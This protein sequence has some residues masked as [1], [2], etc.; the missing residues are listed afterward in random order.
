MAFIT[1]KKDEEKSVKTPDSGSTVPGPLSRQPLPGPGSIIG[2]TVTINADITS[3][4]DVT[5]E[6]KVKGN[7]HVGSTLTI[8][9]N[10]N[11]TADIKAMVVRVYGMV[12]GN[13]T[14]T[15]KVEILSL[16]RCTGNIQSEK[17]VVEEGAILN[18]FVNKEEK[19]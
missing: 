16:G 15:S 9:K 3:D 18:G 11:V 13:I 8:G 2:K 14:A 4:E 1:R 17:L 7:I 6:G 12:K 19:Q 5:I 10:G